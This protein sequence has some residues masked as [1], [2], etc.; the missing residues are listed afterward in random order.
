MGF[1]FWIFVVFCFLRMVCFVVN[2]EFLRFCLFLIFIGK[3][4]VVFIG[5]I[6]RLF[7]ERNNYVIVYVYV[8][9][10]YW[11]DF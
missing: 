8:W 4:Y 2:D 10:I 9:N 7:F 1:F 6:I 11:R 5:E 3:G